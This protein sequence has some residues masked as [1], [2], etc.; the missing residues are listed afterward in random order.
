MLCAFSLDV[1]LYHLLIANCYKLDIN[2]TS[3]NSAFNSR[4]S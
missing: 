2:R 1:Y 3:F 4:L